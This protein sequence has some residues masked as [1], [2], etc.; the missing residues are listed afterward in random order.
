MI[1]VKDT[2][3]AAF[4]ADPLSGPTPLDVEFADESTGDPPPSSWHWDLGDGTTSTFQNPIHLYQTPGVFDVTLI[5]DNGEMKD[6]LTKVEY[7]TVD[8]GLVA[9]FSAEPLAGESPLIVQFTDES[10]GDPTSHEWE[11]GDGGGSQDADPQYTY[12][13]SN[14][15]TVTLTVSDG[16]NTDSEVKEDYIIVGAT[17]VYDFMA[18]SFEL[19]QNYPNPFKDITTISYELEYDCTINLRIYNILGEEI[20]VFAAGKFQAPSI[21][22]L[23]WNARDAS[24][25]LVPAGVYYYEL[26]IEGSEYKFSK[27]KEMILVR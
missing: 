7:I 15:Y 22:R 17:G 21:Y 5:V 27:A 6:T 19:Y 12:N 26:I 10:S 24:G 8:S 18:N 4:S 23:E 16:I 11:F 9:Q 2:L 25:K 20:R 1:H 14:T 13:N 3:K